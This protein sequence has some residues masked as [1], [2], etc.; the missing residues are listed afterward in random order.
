MTA[1]VR[2]G[3]DSVPFGRRGL[4]CDASRMVGA[5]REGSQ[6]RLRGVGR[7]WLVIDAVSGGRRTVLLLRTAVRAR[8]R[9]R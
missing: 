6:G 8:M 4:A 2:G 3:R 7:A 5:W 9:F 1:P